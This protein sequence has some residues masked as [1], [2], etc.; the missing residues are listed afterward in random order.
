[1]TSGRSGGQPLDGF[2]AIDA[3]GDNLEPVRRG[4]D[5]GQPGPD[6]RLVVDER[7]TD[8]GVRASPARIASFAPSGSVQLT[9]QPRR[10]GPAVSSPPSAV[11]RSRMPISP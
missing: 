10:V 3:L 7:D 2:V 11:A 9:R 4:E 5:P 8:H 6:D 1:M